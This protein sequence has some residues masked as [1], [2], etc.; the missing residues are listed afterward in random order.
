MR[1]SFSSLHSYSASDIFFGKNSN[2][3]QKKVNKN[4]LGGAEYGNQLELR[5]KTKSSAD[6][7]LS[8]AKRLG[9]EVSEPLNYR[10]TDN[11]GWM[12]KV[13]EPHGK[14]A[15]DL[16]TPLGILTTSNSPGESGGTLYNPAPN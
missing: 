16:F 2:K 11:S 5:F 6:S 9:F 4:F 1:L 14:G 8:R 12:F 3:D 10:S 7:A 15:E 13:S